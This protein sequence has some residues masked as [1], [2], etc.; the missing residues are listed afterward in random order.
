MVT[1]RFL[2]ESSGLMALWNSPDVQRVLKLM[3]IIFLGKLLQ[4]RFPDKN[5]NVVQALLLQF[6]VPATL[7][8]GLSKETIELSHLKLIA[9]GIVFVLARTV[10]SLVSCYGVLGTSQDSERAAQ[11]RT[12]IFEI[13]TTASALS[14]I[15]FVAAFLGD[16][17]V[18]SAAIVDLPMKL[19]MLIVMPILLKTF[20]EQP[21]GGATGGGSGVLDALKGM[22]KDTISLSLFFGIMIS[23]ITGGGGT[24]ALGFPGKAID[25]LAEAQTPVLFLLIGLKLSFQSNTP[26]FCVVLLL[27]C[28]GVLLIMVNLLVLVT[29]P[30]EEAA[31]FLAFFVQGA[32]SVVGMGVI[33]A[34]IKS[35]VK[36]YS[37]DFAFDIVGMAFPIS[38]L[39]QCS[40]G[41]VG[42]SYPKVCGMVGLM[43]M[44]I[45]GVLRVAFSST[46]SVAEKVD[47]EA[48]GA[49]LTGSRENLANRS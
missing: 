45:A 46:F 19:Y 5:P 1:A 23:L 12:A 3:F 29:D 15:P 25:A 10:A 26:L 17:W 16:A 39:M 28:Q 13:S 8:K 18:G 35:G 9:G 4:G 7:F 47:P 30:P 21:E 31:L 44:A 22:T 14:V 38:S 43:L 48:G 6:L 36:G 11:R 33:T 49:Q 34:T 32:P 42:T 2:E 41:I 20:G 40:V 27:A 24:A 37:S